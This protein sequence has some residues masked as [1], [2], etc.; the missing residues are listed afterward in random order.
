MT[1]RL[2][3][4][5]ALAL[6]ACGQE[7]ASPAASAPAT[8]APDAFCAEHG[9]ME[10]VCT[11]CN[12]KL[13]AIFQ[14]KGAWCAEHG[15]P[16]SFCPTCRPDLGGRPAVDLGP[17]APADGTVIQL[18]SRDTA[19]LAGI[20]TEVAREAPLADEVLVL[21]A[22]AWDAARRAEVHARLPGIVREVLVELGARVAAGAPLVRIESGEVMALRSRR[23]VAEARV[24]AAR[25][26]AERAAALLE[27]GIGSQRDVQ[28]AQFELDAALAERQASQ[29]ALDMVG[30]LAE[31]GNLYTLAAP[32]AGVCVRRDAAI[33][34]LVGA[35]TLLCEIVDTASVWA[36]L[37]VP[38]TE[39]ARVR[40]GQPVF[41]SAEALGGR[42]FRGTIDHVAPEIDPRSRT[43]KARV[44][45]DNPDGVLR[46]NLFVRARI[47]A[48]TEEV[49]VL[50]PRD[51]V[52]RARGQEF[53]F[54]EVAADRFEA[55]R[56][57]VVGHCGD[58]VALAR[59]ARPGD[60]VATRGS[61]LLK[62]EILKGDIG[63]GCCVEE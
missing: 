54:V 45:L 58:L 7:P 20:E 30:L 13:V 52:Q 57:S 36:V 11:K 32:F 34:R 51:A 33:G 21:G 50:V 44:R 40:A 37:D 9:V 15:F 27:R 10:A 35:E 46:A 3:I 22:I 5:A 16:E 18:G 29:A 47:V 19:R 49:R 28:E 60:R 56:A 39:L 12:S 4:L 1:R 61:F 59:G 24:A 62:T 6:A 63:A 41:V 23:Q 48:G 55:R 38:E 8:P 31:N 43:V 42:E 53:V 14:E 25:P 26:A 2:V 17:G